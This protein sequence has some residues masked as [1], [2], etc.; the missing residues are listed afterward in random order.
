MNLSSLNSEVDRMLAEMN[1]IVE[2][3]TLKRFYMVDSHA[4]ADRVKARHV[5]SGATWHPLIVVINQ[6]EYTNE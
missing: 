6:E 5:A 2:Q 3:R 4:E 1:L